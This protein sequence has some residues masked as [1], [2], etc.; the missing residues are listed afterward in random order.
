L[1]LRAAVDE[2]SHV[3]HPP[4]PSRRV[5]ISPAAVQRLPPIVDDDRRESERFADDVPSSS[6]RQRSGDSWPVEYTKTRDVGTAA[7]GSL[8]AAP[9]FMIL[10]DLVRNRAQI[11]RS[12]RLPVTAAVSEEHLV[13]SAH[14]PCD[15]R[16]STMVLSAS[17][18]ANVSTFSCRSQKRADRR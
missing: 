2:G 9:P 18:T 6:S 10:N 5:G 16:P 4:G 12:W 8:A 17:E 1:I 14:P 15:G 13:R 11:S 3:G 7:V